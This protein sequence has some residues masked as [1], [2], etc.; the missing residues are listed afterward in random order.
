MK[1]YPTNLTQELFVKAG[2]ANA[3]W[4]QT[5]FSNGRWLNPM[6]ASFLGSQLG[7]KRI[8]Q[9]LYDLHGLKVRLITINKEAQLM[10]AIMQKT[11]QERHLDYNEKAYLKHWYSLDGAILASFDRWWPV[12][13][14]TVLNWHAEQLTTEGKIKAGILYK[15]LDA[16]DANESLMAVKGVTDV[17]DDPDAEPTAERAAA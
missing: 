10:P 4:T 3:E 7:M 6:L 8:S 2:I 9:G 14:N 15:L 16:A 11:G 13:R 1:P 17:N 12:N 5:M